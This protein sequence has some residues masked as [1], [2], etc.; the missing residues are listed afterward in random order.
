MKTCSTWIKDKHPILIW[1]AAQALAFILVGAYGKWGAKVGTTPLLMFLA[2]SLIGI[3]AESSIRNLTK[4][5]N[6]KATL[7]LT[8]LKTF[9]DDNG[10]ELLLITIKWIGFS[11]AG[12]AL[13]A[14]AA[15]LTQTTNL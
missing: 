11:V 13:A 9:R 3:L 8:L 1:L 5:G 15:N 2:G 4:G 14:M 12:I 6:I 7:K 10:P